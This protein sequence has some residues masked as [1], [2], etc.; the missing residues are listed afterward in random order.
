MPKGTIRPHGRKHMVDFT[1]SGHRERRV[2][3]SR[4]EAVALLEAWRAEDARG[5][6]P[7]ATLGAVLDG[8]VHGLRAR[9]AGKPA[10]I[11]Q[12]VVHSGHLE[13]ILGRARPAARLDVVAIDEF[14]AARRAEGVKASSINGTLRVLRAALRRAG[15]RGVEV[16]MLRELRT[17]PTRLASLEEVRT[18]AAQIPY[19]YDLAILLG[20]YAG[21]RNSEIRHLTWDDIRLHDRVVRVTAKPAVGWSPKS[22]HEREVP[23]P[24]GGALERAFLERRPKKVVGNTDWLFP[25]RDGRPVKSIYRQVREAFRGAGFYN[26]D[27]RSGLH[28][29]RR[30]WASLLLEKGATLEEVRALGGWADLKTVQRYVASTDAARR[31]AQARLEED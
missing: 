1:T 26:V 4:P 12:A 23:F 7:T 20:G 6:R 19:P 10:T 3:D 21:L 15:V 5:E 27:A 25:G 18:I 31:G 11:Q 13:R 8:Y 16:R 24:E 2:V 28:M 22:H 9:S 14:I 30:T 29:L 17:L